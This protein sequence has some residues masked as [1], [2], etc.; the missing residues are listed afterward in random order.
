MHKYAFWTQE[1]L[2][3]SSMFAFTINGDNHIKNNYEIS[4]KSTFTYYQYTIF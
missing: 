4:V 1:S 3:L 2:M